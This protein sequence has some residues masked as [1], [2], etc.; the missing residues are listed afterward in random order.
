MGEIPEDLF[1]HELRNARFSILY[2]DNIHG[3]G[4]LAEF[5]ELDSAA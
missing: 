4:T 3:R 1:L 2:L 5:V